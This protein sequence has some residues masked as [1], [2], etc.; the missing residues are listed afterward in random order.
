MRYK[1]TI[2]SQKSYRPKSKKRSTVFRPNDGP[3]FKTESKTGH[4]K[5]TTIVT[6]LY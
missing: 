3:F 6:P 2:V 1:K 4:Q 5:C